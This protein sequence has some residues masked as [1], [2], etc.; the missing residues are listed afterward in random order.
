MNDGDPPL[1]GQL[2][3]QGGFRH[4]LYAGGS[5]QDGKVRG[6]NHHQTAVDLCRAQH[7]PV[8]GCIRIPA[9]D[10]DSG[11]VHTGT[12]LVE[13]AGVDQD[14]DPFPGEQLAAVVLP[15]DLFLTASLLVL[16]LNVQVLLY[17]LVHSFAHSYSLQLTLTPV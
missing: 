17:G 5:A 4:G 11:S 9:V 10:P 12:E 3:G 7:K 6:L 13:C 1:G 15:V 16:L 2:D 8:A 14:V